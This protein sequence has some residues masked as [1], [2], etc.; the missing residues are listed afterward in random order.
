PSLCPPP[1][2]DQRGALRPQG[3]RCDKGS[4][5]VGAL[6]AAS[7]TSTPTVVAMAGTATATRT[8]TATATPTGTPIGGAGFVPTNANRPTNVLTAAACGPGQTASATGGV[9]G[10]LRC[11]SYV[12]TLTATG[13]AGT[14]VGG[15]PAVF[16]AATTAV[17]G[18]TAVTDAFACTQSV[19]AS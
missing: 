5:E 6:A 14:L 17:V 11:A 3:P 8:A 12:F 19:P 2:T 4:V 1:L 18:G 10:T 13:P 7:P 15:T 9:A 16:I